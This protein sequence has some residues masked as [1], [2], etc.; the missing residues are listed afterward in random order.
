MPVASSRVQTQSRTKAHGSPCTPYA[1]VAFRCSSAS[2]AAARTASGWSGPKT[3]P[4]PAPG[5][6]SGIGLKRRDLRRQFLHGVHE[7]NQ[8]T[9]DVEGED[10]GLLLVGRVE[11]HLRG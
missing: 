1:L 4:V 9:V 11:L 10:F 7:G 5:T 6:P 8:D 3:R 2:R